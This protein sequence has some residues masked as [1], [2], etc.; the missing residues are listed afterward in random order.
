MKDSVT[1]SAMTMAQDVRLIYYQHD[2]VDEQEGIL[3]RGISTK[4]G[5]FNINVP[6]CHPSEV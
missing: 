2:W 1:A 3:G 4:V 6:C 5:A